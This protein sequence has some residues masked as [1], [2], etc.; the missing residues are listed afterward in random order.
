M[1]DAAIKERSSPDSASAA[2]PAS[3]GGKPI[4]RTRD[5]QIALNRGAIALLDRWRSEEPT[6][7]DVAEGATWPEFLAALDADHPSDRRLFRDAE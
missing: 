2:P 4:G 3:I 7:E 6:P 5:E 1:A